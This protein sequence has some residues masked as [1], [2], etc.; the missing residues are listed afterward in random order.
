[1]KRAGNF[2]I[3]FRYCLILCTGHPWRWHHRQELQSGKPHHFT[4]FPHHRQELCGQFRLHSPEHCLQ[5][6]DP[7]TSF[8]HQL[9]NVSPDSLSAS[10]P[11]KGADIIEPYIPF[12]NVNGITFVGS[13]KEKAV[14]RN[15]YAQARARN[16]AAGIIRCR[17][18]TASRFHL[19]CAACQLNSFVF[20]CFTGL[21]P[22]T[23]RPLKQRSM[24][25]QAATLNLSCTTRRWCTGSWIFTSIHCTC[26][27]GGWCHSSRWE[28]HK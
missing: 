5:R 10:N 9:H 22:R 15:L 19:L 25:P 21:I 16:K 4:V 13:V 2:K 18:K 8:H 11:V 26:S 6:P 14:A 7:K 3:S 1:M 12:R 17:S 24:C 23:W 28:G 20:F 27:Q